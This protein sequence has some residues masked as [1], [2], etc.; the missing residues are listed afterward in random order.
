MCMKCVNNYEGGGKKNIRPPD[1]E[2][3]IAD[4]LLSIPP[5]LLLLWS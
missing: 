1:F 5:L 2:P 4:L 3:I